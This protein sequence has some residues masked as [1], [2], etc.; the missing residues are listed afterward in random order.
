MT[1]TPRKIRTATS[2][3][4]RSPVNRKASVSSLVARSDGASFVNRVASNVI[5][6]EDFLPWFGRESRRKL[7]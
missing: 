2:R 4:A 6:M 5:A 1:R 7:L 3:R